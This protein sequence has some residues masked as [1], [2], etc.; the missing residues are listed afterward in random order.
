[1]KQNKIIQKGYFLG[2]D[3]KSEFQMTFMIC[4]FGYLIDIFDTFLLNALRVSS[5]KSMGLDGEQITYV[6]SSL[7]RYQILGIVIGSI[8]WGSVSDFYGRKKAVLLPIF[9]YSL[10][11]F[12]CAFVKDPDTYKLL[13]FITGLG[14]GGEMGAAITLILESAPQNK[15]GI[16]TSILGAGGGLGALLAGFISRIFPWNIVYILGGFLG[17]LLLLL[18]IKSMES[19][20]FKTLKE[21]NRGSTFLNH[22]L[23]F[24]A[25]FKRSKDFF[26]SI[27]LGTPIWLWLGMIVTFAPE[28]F[29]KQ[30]VPDNITTS[31]ALIWTYLGFFLGDITSGF[32]SQKFGSRK[33]VYLT[34]TVATLLTTMIWLI[35]YDH[36]YL[37]FLFLK[38]GFSITGFFAGYWILFATVVGELFN[39]EWRGFAV[40]LAPQ[41]LRLTVI[42]MTFLFDWQMKYLN[43]TALDSVKNLAIGILVLVMVVA[44]HLKETFS[45]EL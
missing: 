13:R 16:Y 39:T 17:L 41:L 37:N 28:I 36:G 9:I 4:F 40:T 2:C 19:P 38:F 24:F 20:Y 10:A 12:S 35:G 8:I 44:F 33:V 21:G 43:F 7:L 5:L 25:S 18:R 6:G 29:K 30:G 1:M 22:P 34:F 3:L 11:T 31:D 32:L 15:R 42:P 45:K 14:L 23:K 26:V 27:L